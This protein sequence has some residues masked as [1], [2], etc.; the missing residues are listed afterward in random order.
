MWLIMYG[1]CSA[2]INFL[3]SGIRRFPSMTTIISSWDVPYGIVVVGNRA[4][5]F[6]APCA[7]LSLSLSL[8]SLNSLFSGADK[9]SISLCQSFSS[10]NF[11]ESCIYFILWYPRCCTAIIIV[12]TVVH[13]FICTTTMIIAPQSKTY[14]RGG[15]NLDSKRNFEYARG[16]VALRCCCI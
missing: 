11:V 7:D 16:N 12:L 6:Q 14:I 9:F 2:I 8:T 3:S 1:F 4:F 10:C 15:I 13:N 5:F